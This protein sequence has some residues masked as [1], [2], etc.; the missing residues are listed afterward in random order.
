MPPPLAKKDPVVQF[1]L[2][3]RLS[4]E[5]KKQSCGKESSEKCWSG[6]V[7]ADQLNKP[8]VEVSHS[9]I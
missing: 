3:G 5:V 4:K 1:I 2:M 6:A 7:E 9:L 8:G